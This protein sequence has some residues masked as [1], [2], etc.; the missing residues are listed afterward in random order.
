MPCPPLP[1]KSLHFFDQSSVALIKKLSLEFQ[2]DQ[3]RFSVRAV[4]QFADMRGFAPTQFSDKGLIARCRIFFMFVLAFR[5]TN[6]LPQTWNHDLADEFVVLIQQP[7]TPR[8]SPQ[9]QNDAAGSAV[10]G[11]SFA[12]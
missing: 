12:E 9:H 4:I 5:K 6:G 3:R 1:Q 11:K 8:F 7:F 10:V 2:H